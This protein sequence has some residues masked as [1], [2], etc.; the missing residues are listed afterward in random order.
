MDVSLNLEAQKQA[1]AK[2]A[3]AETA[4][5]I[6]QAQPQPLFNA[7]AETAGTVASNSASTS[8][9]GSFSALA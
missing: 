6:A 5:T 8:G 7:E 3:K 4:G 1:Q 2:D 9:G